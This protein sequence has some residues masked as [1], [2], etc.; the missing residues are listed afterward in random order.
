MG[1]NGVQMMNNGL[2]PA[3]SYN[4]D[5]YYWLDYI[6]RGDGE[7][8]IVE[9]IN[10]DE[11]PESLMKIQGLIWKESEETIKDDTI[12]GHT[13]KVRWIEN[14]KRTEISMDILP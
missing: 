9:L 14:Y 12:V 3:D 2:A 1:G 11:S 8:T 4:F 5:F 13:E 10:S 6:V 7:Q